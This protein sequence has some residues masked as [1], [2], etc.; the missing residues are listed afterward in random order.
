MYEFVH[1]CSMGSRL[2][3]SLIDFIA[4]SKSLHITNGLLN[5]IYVKSFCLYVYSNLYPCFLLL[6]ISLPIYSSPPKWATVSIIRSLFIQPLHPMTFLRPSLINHHSSIIFDVAPSK[7]FPHPWLNW[8]FLLLRCS[9]G[10]RVRSMSLRWS[11]LH[12]HRHQSL[13]EPSPVRMQRQP[14]HRHS[15]CLLKK[16]G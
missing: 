11:V 3:C 10:N 7:S 15:Q 6:L 8:I 12:P 2:W 14:R 9:W 5:L 16:A 1:V 13:S 4:E